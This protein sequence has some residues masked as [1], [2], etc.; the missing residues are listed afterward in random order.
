MILMPGF[1][2]S[3]PDQNYLDSHPSIDGI[4]NWNSW[5]DESAGKVVVPTQVDQTF[6][7]LSASNGDNFFMMGMSPLQ[8]KHIDG[9]QNWYRR[10]EHNFEERIGQVLQ[11]QPDMLEV[12]TW[13]DA[14]ESHYIGNSWPE[15]IPSSIKAYTTEYDH[16]GYW[17]VLKSFIQAW[18]RGDTDTSHMVPTNG[19][20]AQGVFYHHTLL[21]TST[22]PS[23][24]MG[25]PR[26]LDNVEDIVAVSPS[27][28][29][30]LLE[31]RVRPRIAEADNLPQ[32]IIL[33]AENQA[34]LH[35][36]VQCDDRQLGV[37]D[38]STGYNMFNFAGLSA[39]VVNVTVFGP[40]G[41][42]V[43]GVGPIAVSLGSR[44]QSCP[45]CILPPLQQVGH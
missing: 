23:D 19:K 15:P 17:E 45:L 11:M 34:G 24:P 18:K 16:R 37:A 22:C 8:F 25:P 39:G 13:N 21:T 29:I 40:D 6:Q 32:G 26:G 4:F 35:A 31:T 10:G 3:V 28:R 7:T 41:M 38:L 12:Q 14:G 36:S 1:Y 43:S 9:G 44:L 30:P 33:V 27:S 2:E 5:A 20:A 42:V